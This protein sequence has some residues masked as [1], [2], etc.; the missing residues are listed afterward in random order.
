M[1]SKCATTIAHFLA[2]NIP[3][4]RAKENIIRY[5]LEL[6]ITAFVG[7]LLMICVSV[8]GG[9]PLIWLPFIFGFAPIRTTAGGYHAPSHLGCYIVT[10][11]TYSFFMMLALF[12][13]THLWIYIVST[14]VSF[15]L[16]LTL[17]P[18]EAQ[19]KPLSQRK[20]KANRRA[21]LFLAAVELIGAVLLFCLEVSSL[22]ATM[23]FYGILAA[24]L[25]L[26]AA[27]IITLTERRSSN[28]D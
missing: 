28:E 19:N 14:A 27:K 22:W 1:E 21:S 25:S 23:F 11:A 18:V 8:I 5:G 13:R 7:L 26:V 15:L 20:R 17:S 4:A 10:T 6:M 9:H 12:L 2:I 16:V 24:S 3:E